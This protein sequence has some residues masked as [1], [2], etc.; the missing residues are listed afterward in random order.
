MGLELLT[1]IEGIGLRAPP[2]HAPGPD[3]TG[4]SET[5]YLLSTFMS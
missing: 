3:L 4:I 1:P 5:S 2:T